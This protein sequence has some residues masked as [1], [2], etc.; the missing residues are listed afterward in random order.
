MTGDQCRGLV[1]ENGIGK[2]KCR[3]ALRDLGNLPF[4]MRARVMFVRTN[5]CRFTVFNSKV[6][7]IDHGSVPESCQSV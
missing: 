1:D 4:G 7:R 6:K 3:D 5:G 2:A